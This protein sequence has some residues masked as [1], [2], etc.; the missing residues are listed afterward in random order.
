MNLAWVQ[1]NGTVVGDR[2][3]IAVGKATYATHAQMAMRVRAIAGYLRGKLGCT[4]GDR[5]G[6]ISH[7]SAWYLE[8]LFGIWHAGLVAAPINS[9]LHAREFEYILQHSDCRAV[10]VEDELAQTVASIS[11]NCAGLKHAIVLGGSDWQAAL[12]FDGIDV[13]AR[14]P[15][16][17]AWLFYT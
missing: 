3:A 8:A 1:R 5:V 15:S 17:H 6:I 2:P 13:V 4:T 10:F 11:G 9:R 12:G 16:D 7:N 14:A